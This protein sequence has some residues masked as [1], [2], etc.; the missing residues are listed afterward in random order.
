MP[1]SYVGTF[2]GI[3]VW[4]PVEFCNEDLRVPWP[5]LLLHDHGDTVSITYPYEKGM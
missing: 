4:V 2:S 5:S 1:K 3:P